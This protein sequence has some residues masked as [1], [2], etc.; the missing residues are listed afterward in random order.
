MTIASTRTRGII[1]A[2]AGIGLLVIVQLARSD[3]SEE[4]ADVVSSEC[5][6]GQP[7]EHVA[8]TTLIKAYA[9]NELKAQNDYGDRPLIVTGTV[10]RI[11]LDMSD[12]PVVT[13]ATDEL[14]SPAA[15][16]C[17]GLEYQAA[18]LVQGQDVALL[19]RDLHET[20]GT[21]GLKNCELANGDPVLDVA[22][23]A[24]N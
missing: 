14:I 12:E 9:A 2:A 13:F 20:L 17:S 10:K 23:P 15:R 18:E 16:F 3:S 1:I 6:E 22:T 11:S 24:E 8:I 7:G 4:K 5:P 21:P 19:C